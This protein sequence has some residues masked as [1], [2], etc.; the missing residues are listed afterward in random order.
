MLRAGD[1]GPSLDVEVN[2]KHGSLSARSRSTAAGIDLATASSH[3]RDDRIETAS[4]IENNSSA[5]LS[6]AS[7]GASTHARSTFSGYAPP[8]F[9]ERKAL[10]PRDERTSS[11]HE[12]RKT[13]GRKTFVKVCKGI[14]LVVPLTINEEAT[15]MQ[16]SGLAKLA[17]VIH[18]RESLSQ[19]RHRGATGSRSG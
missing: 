7:D 2:Q 15:S 8:S 18:R 19:D 13:V 4:A 9:I 14:D 5:N 16:D 12:P 6:D 11:Q 10:L 1:K 17:R 3:N